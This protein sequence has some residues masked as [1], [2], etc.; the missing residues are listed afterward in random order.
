MARLVR[1][2]CPSA[3]H[4]ETPLRSTT[5]SSKC[6]ACYEAHEN[7]QVYK[8]NM[9]DLCLHEECIDTNIPY[10]H[11]HPLKLNGI[12]YLQSCS[13]CHTIPTSIIYQCSQCSFRICIPCARKPLIISQSKAHDHELLQIPIEVSFTCY[14]CGLCVTEY[15]YICLQCL[16]IIDFGCIYLPRVI[17][18][19]RHDHRISRVS[20]LGP[21]KWIC[22]V[23]YEHVNGEY[24]AYSCLACSYVAHSKCATSIYS[25]D[26]ILPRVIRINRHDHRISRV[27]SLGPGKW[28]CGVCYEHVNGEYGAYSCLVCS[29]VAH[30]KCAT[31]IYSWDRIELEGVPEEEEEEEEEGRKPF[32]VIDHNQIKHFSHEHN[33]KVSLS[34]SKLEEPREHCYACTIPLYSELCYI[35]TQC[36]FILHDACANLPLKKRHEYGSRKFKLSYAKRQDAIPYFSCGACHRFCTGFSYMEEY[37]LFTIDVRCAL[38]SGAI[39]HESHPHLLVI[40]RDMVSKRRCDSCDS[41]CWFFLRCSDIDNCGGY[42]LCFR[43]ATLPTLVR[44][45]YDDHPLSL[46]YS[47]RIVNV[48][49]CCG[50]CEEELDSKSWFYKCSECG[51]TLHTKCVFNYLIHSRPGYSLQMGYCDSFYLLPNHHLSRPICYLCKTRCTGDF[52]LNHKDDTNLFICC[53]CKIY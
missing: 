45:K 17:R 23:C 32:E 49:L 19:N 21:G 48:I 24:G 20:S 9:C 15:P 7:K 42:N 43:C 47:E 40:T 2:L 11:A 12:N 8:C 4:P 3:N 6:A 36:D 37:S 28:I 13:L 50:I 27:S 41:V 35:C 1:R 44:H 39:K 46:C 26:R 51:S 16:F 25:W 33:L 14:A 18:I 5:I 30:S 52:F 53:S 29:Y 22:G 10:L 34:S 38:I 31:S